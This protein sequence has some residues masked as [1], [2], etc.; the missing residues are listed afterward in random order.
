[1]LLERQEHTQGVSTPQLY[2][3]LWWTSAQPALGK[4]ALFGAG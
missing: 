3:L 1:M 2:V 4:H